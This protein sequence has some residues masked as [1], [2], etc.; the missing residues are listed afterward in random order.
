[1]HNIS[2]RLKNGEDIPESESE[3]LRMLDRRVHSEAKAS[4]KDI[5]A[6][7]ELHSA[8]VEEQLTHRSNH[9]NTQVSQHSLAPAQD[10]HH[11]SVSTITNKDNTFSFHQ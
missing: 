5:V 6:N 4:H 9:Y 8:R 3:V 2:K 7:K 1:M 10:P 11:L